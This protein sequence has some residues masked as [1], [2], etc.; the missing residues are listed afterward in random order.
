M[1]AGRPRRRYALGSA[2]TSLAHALG[3]VVTGEGI[4]AAAHLAWAW[5]AACDQGQ[6]YHFVPPLPAEAMTELLDAGLLA[7]APLP[8]HLPARTA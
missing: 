1:A 5:R 4:K 3:M 8:A 2:I 7:P 6:G